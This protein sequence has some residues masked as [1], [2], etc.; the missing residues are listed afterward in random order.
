MLNEKDALAGHDIEALH[1][2]RVASRRLRVAINVFDKELVYCIP[3]GIRKCLRKT[4]RR[5][6]EVRDYDVLIELLEHDLSKVTGEVDP[7]LRMFNNFCYVE[8]DRQRL[9][10]SRFMVGNSY[11]AM[12]DYFLSI[13]NLETT[14][15]TAVLNQQPLDDFTCAAIQKKQTGLY[16]PEVLSPDTPVE[17]LHAIR[18]SVKKLRYT[19]EFFAGTFKGRFD[20]YLNRL[21]LVQDHLGKIHDTH[22]LL[23]KVHSFG[24]GQGIKSAYESPRLGTK[25]SKEY[26]HRKRKTLI[27][28]I[29]KFPVVYQNARLSQFR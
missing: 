6:G 12:K 16:P 10:L 14:E 5:L 28:M 25:S 23:E 11:V 15:T 3:K 29:E 4:G 13:R 24:T 20:D 1:R 2:M 21:K 26:I 9:R 17:T 22:Y 7:M 18:I 8:R 19:V 27:K